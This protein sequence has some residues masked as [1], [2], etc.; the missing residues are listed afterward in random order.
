ME[1]YNGFLLSLSLC[2][3]IGLANM[4]MITLSMQRGFSKGV[5]L[6]IGTCIGDL[7][8][9]ILAMAGMAVLLQYEV[10]RWVLWLGGSAVLAYLCAK[11]ATS[12]L[13]V[14]TGVAQVDI[15]WGRTNLALFSKGVFLA[16]SSPSAILWFAAVGG[17]IIARQGADA[18]SAIIFLSGFFAAGVFWALV[19]CGLAYHGG[20]MLGERMLKWTYIASAL[21]FAYFTLYV[22]VTGYLEFVMPASVPHH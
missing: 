21:I 4:A 20:R 3:E 15:Q 13:R 16:M 6:G 9:A 2:M 17:A 18:T 1:F 14:K 19:L 12:A 5:W 22:V 8:Y 11:M 10:V 7:V